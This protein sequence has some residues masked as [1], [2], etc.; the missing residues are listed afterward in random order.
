MKRKGCTC[1]PLSL[2]L[3]RSV[4]PCHPAPSLLNNTPYSLS[5]LTRTQSV[6]DVDLARMGQ[7]SLGFNIVG[8]TDRPVDVRADSVTL[9]FFF[10]R[11]G[12][13][14]LGGSLVCFPCH[15]L[16]GSDVLAG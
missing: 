15:S 7:E 10:V 3:S 4:C 1:M 13:V 14:N 11:D 9:R 5:L 12:C 2:S 16:G 6:L 8:G